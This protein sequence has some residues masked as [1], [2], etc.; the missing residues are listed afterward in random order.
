M[1]T[2]ITTPESEHPEQTETSQPVSIWIRGLYMLLFLVITRLAEAVVGL[3]MVIQ[4]ILKAAS[5]NTNQNL[6][7]FGHQMS[8]YL[9]SIVQFQTFNSEEKPFPFAPWPDGKEK[10]E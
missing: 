1:T 10:A 4:F 6:V 2:N 7:R 8:Q 9:Y 3:I 5:G